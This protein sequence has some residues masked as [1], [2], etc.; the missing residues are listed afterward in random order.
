[1]FQPSELDWS[2][3]TAENTASKTTASLHKINKVQAKKEEAHMI[4]IQE[5]VSEENN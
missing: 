3:E 4:K 1:M 5:N 2:R